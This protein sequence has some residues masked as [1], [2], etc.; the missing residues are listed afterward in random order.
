MTDTA[1]AAAAARSCVQECVRN[2]FPIWTSLAGCDARRCSGEF[3]QHAASLRNG[4]RMQA[5]TR[6]AREERGLAIP[7]KRRETQQRACRTP[8]IS[9]SYFVHVPWI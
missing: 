3:E 1:F 6:P 7:N 8:D 5:R 2:N 9:G 4:L